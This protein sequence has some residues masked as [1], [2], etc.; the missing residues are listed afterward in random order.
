MGLK[1][2]ISRIKLQKVTE[3]SVLEIQ[4]MTAFY[5]VL[6]K[7]QEKRVGFDVG[8]VM[9]EVYTKTVFEKF[10]LDYKRA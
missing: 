5:L 2:I 6:L 9:R 3:L 1:K 8:L 4:E 10:L 7:I